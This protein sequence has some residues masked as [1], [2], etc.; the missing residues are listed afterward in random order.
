MTEHCEL[1]I[2]GAGPAGMAAAVTAAEAGLRPVLLDEQPGPGGQIYRAVE[3][4]PVTDPAVLGQDYWY[5]RDLAEALR[6]ADV[7]YRPGALVWHITRDREISVLQGQHAATLHAQRVILATG[8][9]ERAFPIPGWDLPGVMGAGAGQVL[10]KSSG[11]VP[12]GPTVLAGTGPLLMLLAVQYLRAGVPLA[13]VL[14][15]TVPGNRWRALRHLPQAALRGAPYLRKGLEMLKTLR[16]HGVRHIHGVNALQAEGEEY[17][18]SVAWRRNGRWERLACNTLLLHQGVVPNVQATRVLRCEHRWD[19][20][21]LAWRPQLT[22]SLET[23]ASGIAVAG[24]GSGIV[25]ARGS[26]LQGHV[27]ALEALYALEYLDEHGRDRQ[28][29]PLKAQLGREAAP[30]P[31]LDTLFQPAAHWMRPADDCVVCRCE[32]VTA[33]ELRRVAAQGCNGPNQTKSFTR[34]GMG[35]CQGRMCGLTVAAVLAEA[36]GQSM[37]QTGYYRI[38]P[39]LKPITLGQLASAAREDAA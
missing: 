3:R 18:T 8:A 20:R 29:A 10:L 12:E 28:M 25:G 4:T 38:R 39:P 2:V 23:D 34:C 32:K 36:N 9:Q 17:L 1:A 6:R 5:G 22:G 19:A 33:G 26:E 31:F 37:E 14:E 21:Q 35:P 24:D 13:A 15:T 11:V 7:D 27:A 30:R 16:R